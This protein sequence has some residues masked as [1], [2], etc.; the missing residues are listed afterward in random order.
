M[1]IIKVPWDS[2]SM[3]KNHGCQKAP[4]AI[5]KAMEDIF[6]NE[7]WQATGCEVYTVKTYAK[8]FGKTMDT[9][10]EQ[11]LEAKEDAIL[12]GGDHSI[13]YPA[14]KAY[15]KNHKD[16][17]VVMIDA[18]PDCESDF[19]PPTHEDFIRAIVNQK[20]IPAKRILLIGTRNLHQDEAAYLKEHGIKAITMKRIGHEGL[21]RTLKDIRKTIKD[22]PS[23]YL[24]VD[25]DA[26]DPSCAP[27]TGYPEPG[28]LTTRE[29]LTII[30]A[31]K[32]TGKVRMADVA[33]ANP[34]LDHNN[35]TVK[36]A[37]K[38]TKELLR[39]FIKESLS[40]K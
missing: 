21:Q 34:E 9:I 15:A 19:E 7:D 22:W 38:I 27:G 30:Q 12:L 10:H 2:G 3:N 36:L 35:M 18:H 29:L 17:G 32:E 8:D 40:L 16:G 20:V 1:R 25:I 23:I 33:E 31:L 39:T 26:A 5:L 11:A 37:A 4:D 24:T 28:G 14:V 13:T 6:L